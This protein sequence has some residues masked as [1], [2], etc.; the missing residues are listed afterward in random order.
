MDHSGN[1]NLALL[2]S[3]DD[4]IAVDEQLAYIFVV[5]LRDLPAGTRKE[6]QRLGLVHNFLDDNACVCG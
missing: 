3:I 6:R 4:P 1:H 2:Q 5:K